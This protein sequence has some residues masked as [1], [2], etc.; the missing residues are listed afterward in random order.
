MRGHEPPIA[1]VEAEAM[2]RRAQRRRL[3]IASVPASTSARTALANTRA[4]RR[5]S[6]GGRELHRGETRQLG[7]RAMNAIERCA[8]SRRRAASRS[9]ATARRSSS[10]TASRT[11]GTACEQRA[12]C[13]LARA[14]DR[15]RTR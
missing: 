8:A 11:C 15:A 7:M 6:H 12:L 1:L 2:L 4:G 13:S 10:P 14:R 3:R 9:R 5:G